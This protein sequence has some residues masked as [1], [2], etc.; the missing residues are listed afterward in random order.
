MF[1]FNT[2][3]YTYDELPKQSMKDSC[4]TRRLMAERIGRVPNDLPK[5]SFTQKLCGVLGWGCDEAQQRDCAKRT[6]REVQ[7]VRKGVFFNTN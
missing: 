6:F 3:D 5:E 7:D 1:K 2:R 4:E